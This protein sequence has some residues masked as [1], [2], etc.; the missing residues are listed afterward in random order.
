MSPSLAVPLQLVAEGGLATLP[1]WHSAIV[2]CCRYVRLSWRLFGSAW[3]C[4]SSKRS[5]NGAFRRMSFPQTLRPLHNIQT[6]AQVVHIWWMAS[7]P[8]FSLVCFTGNSNAQRSPEFLA[9]QLPKLTS[10]LVLLEDDSSESFRKDTS[11]VIHTCPLSTHSRGLVV[12]HTIKQCLFAVWTM[13]LLPKGAN[14][15]LALDNASIRCI[16]DDSYAGDAGGHLS[17]WRLFGMQ[18]FCMARKSF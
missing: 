11:T 15:V 18:V 1:C 14:G 4:S 12:S 9:T 6:F 10:W 16:T 7:C 13:T 2:S 3:G 5:G 17:H 8:F